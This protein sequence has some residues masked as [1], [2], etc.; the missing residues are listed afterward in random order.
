[1][2]TALAAPAPESPHDRYIRLTSEIVEHER[3]KFAP[4]EPPTLAETY[5]GALRQGVLS[6]GQFTSLKFHELEIFSCQYSVDT[7]VLFPYL[8]FY[9]PAR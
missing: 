2:T 5:C 1:M 4:M 8:A 3:E 9:P 7:P 6:A